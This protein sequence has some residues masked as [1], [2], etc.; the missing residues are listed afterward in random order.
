MAQ[1]LKV[2]RL[3]KAS[4][5]SSTAVLNDKPKWEKPRKSISAQVCNFVRALLML[6]FNRT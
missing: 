3:K 1:A 5:K 4:K 6:M 2:K